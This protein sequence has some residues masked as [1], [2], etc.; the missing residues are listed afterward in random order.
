MS[1]AYGTASASLSWWRTCGEGVLT[2]S[3]S[4]LLRYAAEIP[5][6]R[7]AS[8]PESPRTSRACLRSVPN[9]GAKA[10]FSYS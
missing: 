9:G 2:A 5:A 6:A 7:A 3:L 8:L 1:S 4:S 10:P